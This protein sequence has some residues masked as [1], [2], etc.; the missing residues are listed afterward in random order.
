MDTRPIS[1]GQEGVAVKRILQLAKD[2]YKGQAHAKS[3]FILHGTIILL[4][5]LH[6]SLPHL[7]LGCRQVTE[8]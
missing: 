3:P 6:G 2:I 4:E 5:T 1:L 7:S 8:I